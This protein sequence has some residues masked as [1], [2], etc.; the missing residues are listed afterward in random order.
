MQSYWS[1]STEEYKSEQSPFDL[2]YDAAKEKNTVKLD[3]ALK[4]A[5]IDVWNQAISGTPINALASEGDTDS[6]DFLL[7]ANASVAHA[8]CGYARGGYRE[9]AFALLD[10][11]AKENPSQLSFLLKQMAYGFALSVKDTTGLDALLAKIRHEYPDKMSSLLAPIALGLAQRGEIDAANEVLTDARKKYPERV[12]DVLKNIASG[13][14]LAG[15]MSAI[16]LFL[17]IN[18]AFFTPELLK[19][20]LLTIIT[21]LAR[22]ERKKESAEFAQLVNDHYSDVSFLNDESILAAEARGLGLA[23][24]EEELIKDYIAHYKM[25]E[26]CPYAA[27]YIINNLELGLAEGGHTIKA[28]S[29]IN[30][31]L[32]L[33]VN[34]VLLRQTYGFGLGGHI[35]EAYRS[36]RKLIE[37]DN[38]YTSFI[39]AAHGLGE[40]GRPDVAFG[41]IDKMK[42]ERFSEQDIQ[43]IRELM[44]RH[45][46]DNNHEAETFCILKN[47]VTDNEII[48]ILKSELYRKIP[49]LKFPEKF[50]KFFEK[51]ILEFSPTITQA[52]LVSILTN[53]QGS[54]ILNKPML[55]KILIDTK[56][57]R[58][59]NLDEALKYAGFKPSE[60]T[61]DAIQTIQ[62]LQYSSEMN[63]ST[64]QQQALLQPELTGILLHSLSAKNQKWASVITATIATYL[65]IISFKESEDLLNKLRMAGKTTQRFFKEKH[66]AKEKSSAVPS[67]LIDHSPRAFN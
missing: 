12:N 32:I 42:S 4:L 56:P 66:L 26:N 22:A 29:V 1:S 24:V 60:F 65:G 17:K 15:N 7:K 53:M 55:F 11:I 36:F 20:I 31:H 45:F 64:A 18:A 9:K 59:P 49:S 50:N 8:A 48:A 43:K 30:T 33:D 46:L 62:T 35:T 51:I 67:L 10:K 63:L 54:S 5:C 41:F 14:A 44:V 13:M 16:N 19:S 58:S 28:D 39:W 23:G 37:N 38:K 27:Y 34:S 21:H 3:A 25:P 6:V 61:N 57:Y 40:Y 47:G 2:I 52:L